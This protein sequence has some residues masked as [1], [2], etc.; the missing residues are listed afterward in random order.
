MVREILIRF[1]KSKKTYL[2]RNINIIIIKK[3]FE[4]D[5]IINI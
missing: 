3:G 2:Q 1:T 4:Q 5:W